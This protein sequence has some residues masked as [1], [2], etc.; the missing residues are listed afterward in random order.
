MNI[1][2]EE[3]D[4][5]TRKI[6]IS[7][8]RDYI[9]VNKGVCRNIIK[10]GNRYPNAMKLFIYMCMNMDKTNTIKAFRV[11]T[12]QQAYNF[13]GK[14]ISPVSVTAYKRKLL[15]S[16]FLDYK[17]NSGDYIVNPH[18]V[19]S[20]YSEKKESCS[21]ADE[22]AMLYARFINEAQ[23]TDY[24]RT[25]MKQEIRAYYTINRNYKRD[26]YWIAQQDNRAL[27]VLFYLFSVAD[28][29]NC[30]HVKNAGMKVL[31]EK[32]GLKRQAISRTISLLAG[33]NFIYI[34]KQGRNNEFIINPDLF[35]N[36]DKKLIIH[37]KFPPSLTI[38]TPARRQQ[39]VE[40]EHNADYEELADIVMRYISSNDMEQI[41]GD[42]DVKKVA[43]RRSIVRELNIL[44][45][46]SAASAVIRFIQAL[47]KE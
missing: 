1:T 18:I 3:S 21:F 11:K 22:A 26:L 19:W 10:M 27:I 12:F 45:N 6:R 24:N 40:E 14:V 23:T 28:D 31:S 2:K 43:F 34:K 36:S 39:I 13:D 20:T 17:E 32:L 41:C 8:L 4:T 16:G 38:N 29:Y 5:E 47:D 25:I 7:E 33:Y 9:M 42:T 46:N 30:V 44:G 37:C 35:W 15:D